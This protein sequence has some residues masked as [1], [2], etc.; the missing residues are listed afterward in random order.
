MSD[1]ETL[2]ERLAA[3]RAGRSLPP[4]ERWHP[5][6]QGK[7]GIS[8]DVDG[9]WYYQG[10]EI[11][12]PEMVKLFSSVLRRDADAFVL[13]TPAE[14]LT[15]EVA[16]VPFLAVDFERRGANT[17]QELAFATN[18]G[19]VVIADAV[20]PLSVRGSDD[21]PRPYIRVRGELDARLSRAVYYRLIDIAI[22]HDDAVGV[23]S[24]G[25]FFR[26]GHYMFG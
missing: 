7:S 1:P 17:S 19:D 15:V 21:S 5:S 23:W 22:E 4:V 8:I 26:L 13:V 12:R 20:H 3:A 9:R 16:D 24:G 14:R 11:R 25:T 18:V 2:F 10:S 6:R